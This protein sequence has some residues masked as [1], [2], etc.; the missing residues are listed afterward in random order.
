MRAPEEKKIIAYRSPNGK[1]KIVKLNYN[2]GSIG[3]NIYR[4]SDTEQN[5][6]GCPA[7]W[8]EALPEHDDIPKYILA[9]YQKLT[10]A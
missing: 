8:Y 6:Y 5:K 1:W 7:I 2:D 10:E 3:Y 4:L 9:Q